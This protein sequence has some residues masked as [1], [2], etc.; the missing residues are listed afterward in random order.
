MK[1]Y[2]Y[3]TNQEAFLRGEY[4]FAMDL[5]DNPNYEDYD[6]FD[7]TL[8]TSIEIDVDAVSHDEVTQ[9]AIT[10]IEVRETE[11]RAKS[12]A[13]LTALQQRKS[14]LLSITHQPE[15]AA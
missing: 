7:G 3:I 12:E 11:I 4:D 14:E 5:R 9:S 2:V 1:M 13:E 10:A 8:L 6:W 15:V